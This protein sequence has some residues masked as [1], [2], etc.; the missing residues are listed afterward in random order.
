LILRIF[1]LFSH[2]FKITD[3][4]TGETL[5]NFT[6]AKGDLFLAD[7]AYASKK[8]LSHCLGHGAD[9]ILRL[10]CDGF[11]MYSGNGERIDLQQQLE[12]AKAN[13]VIVLPVF[14][15]LSDYGLGLREMRVCALKKSREEIEKAMQRITRKDSKR[16]K[17][18][19][20]GAKQFNEYIMLMTSPPGS[21]SA[22][23]VLSAYR[24]RWQV[25]LYFKRLKSLLG[26]G[27]IP[28]KRPECMEA[29]LNGKMVLA[30]L[31]EVLL[32]KLDFF[33]LRARKC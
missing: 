24:Y 14:V 29:W 30:V 27:E 4:E 15:D 20:A 16:Q 32:S 23:E 8:S 5:T 25:E 2:E 11:A 17:K 22:D 19:S 28:K 26:A 3:H 12:A 21:I 10:R 33:P 6:A 13:E 18:T 1:C 9:C 7:R 31:F